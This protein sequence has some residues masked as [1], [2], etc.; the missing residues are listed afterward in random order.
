MAYAGIVI[1]FTWRERYIEIINDSSTLELGYKFNTVESYAT[2]KP[3]EVTSPN[4]KSTQ[5]I[6]NGTGLYRIRAEG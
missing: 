3:L 1:T 2:L 5:V 4:V 6:L